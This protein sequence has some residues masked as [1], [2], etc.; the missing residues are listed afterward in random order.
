MTRISLSLSLASA[1][2]AVG[3]G[4]PIDVSGDYSVSTTTGANMCEIDGWSEGD[5]GSGI[6]VTITQDGDQATILVE[7][8]PGIFLNL[9]VGGNRF[10]G[11]V[12][13]NRITAAIMGDIDHTQDGCTFHYAV[14]L[15]ATL[16]GDVIQG[17]LIYDPII[18]DGTDCG[19]L[20]TCTGN[21]QSFNGTRP[22]SGG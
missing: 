9:V 6:P 15:D 21:R 8:A 5:T 19:A 22:P 12:S 13:G 17:T 2:L 18:T 3:C 4:D 10:D 1:V 14:D 20:A 11:Q 16:E 7:G